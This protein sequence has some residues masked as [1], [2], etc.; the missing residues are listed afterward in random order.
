MRIEIDKENPISMAYNS[1]IISF[2]IFVGLFYLFTP[3][4]VQ[5]V[6]QITGTLSISWSLILCYSITF[7]FVFAIFVFMI[8]LNKR[9]E[10]ENIGYEIELKPSIFI[11]N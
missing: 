6:N 10:S 5:V 2:V 7:S 3:S 8:I 4:W 11:G 1:I 9:K